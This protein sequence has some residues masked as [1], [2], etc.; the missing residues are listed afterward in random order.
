MVML[1]QR[2]S[3]VRGA[4]EIAQEQL[5]PAIL[6]VIMI[7]AD[8][9]NCFNIDK[10]LEDLKKQNVNVTQENILRADSA[11]GKDILQKYGIEKLP[12][13][14]IKGEIEKE[15]L[16]GYFDR[17]GDIKKD[18]VVYTSLIP[19]YYDLVQK[20]V[21]GEVTLTHLIDSSC[22]ECAS[23]DDFAEALKKLMFVKEEKLVL[24][25]SPEGKELIKRFDIK[26]IP[27]LLISQEINAYPEVQQQLLTAQAREKNGFY[28]VHSTVPPYRNLTS[29]KVVGL[30]AFIMLKDDSCKECYDVTVNKQILQRF[31][32][33][34]AT[35][36]TYDI[37]SQEGK[38]LVAKYNITN[39]P[40]ILVSPEAS[41]Y[42][43]FVNAWDDVGNIEKDGWY[44]MRFPEIVGTVKDL[45]KNK[46]ITGG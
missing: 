41:V 15:Q 14:I 29:N 8:C 33:H 9:E 10:A 11:E 31:G 43:I 25:D 17:I 21:V 36:K 1:Q 37:S 42:P 6:E 23:L 16:K 19:P 24:Y 38:V 7:K 30:V 2:V 39:V 20:R 18:V 44:V 34:L 26:H 12:A 4:R 28:A 3:K 32:M 5:E 46:I 35:E 27:A 22:K 45:K 40:M 13:L